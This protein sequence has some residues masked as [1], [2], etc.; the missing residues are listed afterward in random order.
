MWL[1]IARLCDAVTETMRTGFLLDYEVS[2]DRNTEQATT[3]L[4]AIAK[5]IHLHGYR[6]IQYNDPLDGIAP[7]SGLNFSNCGL[8]ASVMDYFTIL[9]WPGSKSQDMKKELATQI[10]I[11]GP[12]PPWAHIGVTVGIGPSGGELTSEQA[13]DVNTYIVS[14]K[15]PAVFIWPDYGVPGGDV[16]R[17]Y[18]QDVGLAVGIFQYF[19]FP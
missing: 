5:M 8:L 10:K 11:I 1:P 19:P 14:H 2:D 4:L 15:I 12:S 9:V 18:N 17:Q 7:K 3:A 6:V 13:K 16:R